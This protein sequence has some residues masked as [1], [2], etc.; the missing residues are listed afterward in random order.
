[1][2]RWTNAVIIIINEL[3][4]YDSVL[5]PE[6]QTDNY[7]IL[8]SGR[9]RQERDVDCYIRNDLSYSIISVF[10]RGIVSVFFLNLVTWFQTNN[11]RN[12][13]SPIESIQ[14][15]GSTDWKLE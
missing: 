12:N 2:P 9:N 13:Q 1:M 14:L 11:S 10:P 3:K 5:K 6:I 7:K 8:Q 15:L 4:L